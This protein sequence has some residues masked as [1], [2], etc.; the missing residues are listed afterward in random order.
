MKRYIYL[1]LSLVALTACSLDKDPISEFNEKNTTA[2]GKSSSAIETKAQMQT[3]Y[4][5]IYAFVR[6]SAQ[7]FWTLDFLQN[8][9]TRADNA[10]AGTSGVEITSIEQNSQDASNGNIKRDWQKYLEGINLANVVIANVDKVPDASLTTTERKQWKA[11]AKI[12]KAW[13]L[14]DMVRFWGAV[15]I[16]PI[17]VPEIS[18]ENVEETYKLLFPERTSVAEVYNII[19]TNLEEALVDAPA[20]KT[21]DKFFFSRAVANAL[22]AH[23]YAE[24]PIRDYN[25]TIQYCDAVIGA[26]FSL[27]PNYADLFQLNATGTDAKLRNSSESIF[28]VTYSTGGQTWLSIMFGKNHINPKSKYDWRK[29]CTPSRD[30][31][32]AFDAEGDTVRRDQAVVWGQPS[33]SNY[34]PSDHYAFMYKIRSGA[35]SIIKLRLADI[36][37]LKAEAYAALGQTAE[38]AALVN[39]VRARVGLAAI[40]TSLSQ[41]Q[42]K[43][44]VLKER[45]LEL[46]FEGFRWFD[47]VR[48]DKAV[49]TMNTLNSRD[50]GRLRQTYPLNNNTVLYPVPQTEI[51]KNSKLTQNAGY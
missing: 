26:G 5:A 40:S 10:Y 39:Q 21:N 1:A 6:G 28:E 33:W 7:E 37:L 16:P 29:W 48:N 49:E 38:A 12:L 20:V 3:R 23:V 24:K 32:A 4:E 45:R 22:L 15:P 36:L 50:S 47:L 18:S 41:E 19:R 14:F 8:T 46:A 44:A 11:E 9:E 35:N 25:K 34:Y 13:L 27:V 42:M 30:L 43:E 2:E 51:E 17:E 31:L